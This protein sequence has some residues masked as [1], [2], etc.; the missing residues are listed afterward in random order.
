MMLEGIH[1]IKFRAVVVV[2]VRLLVLLYSIVVLE[3]RRSTV[4]T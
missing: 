4:W 1:N 2:V 3:V